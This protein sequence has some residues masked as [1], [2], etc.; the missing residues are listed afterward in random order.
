MLMLFQRD[1]GGDKFQGY[2]DNRMSYSD[3]QP[4][5]YGFA[6]RREAEGSEDFDSY[7]HDGDHHRAN[8]VPTGFP[9]YSPAGQQSTIPSKNVR[10]EAFSA[11]T[12]PYDHGYHV[13]Y[14]QPN[15]YEYRNPVEVRLS[16]LLFFS[17]FEYV[18]Y[19]WEK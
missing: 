7:I 15:S 6:E 5:M 13:Q 4:E 1:S 18:V 17:L 11:P 3:T 14:K 19:Q 9:Q 12:S 2:G 10:F 8:K 16:I